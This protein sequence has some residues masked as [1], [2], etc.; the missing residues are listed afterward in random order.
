M[1]SYNFQSAKSESY[2]RAHMYRLIVA[3][4]NRFRVLRQSSK[5]TVKRLKMSI[6][7]VTHILNPNQFFLHR[8]IPQKGWFGVTKVQNYCKMTNEP[9][10]KQNHKQKKIGNLKA[11]L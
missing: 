7:M 3:A 5:L 10:I 2:V 6:N 8:N 1:L 4:Q 11:T 9:T